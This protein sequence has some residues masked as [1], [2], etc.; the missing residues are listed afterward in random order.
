MTWERLGILLEELEVVVGER[1]VWG[2]LLR[3]LLPRI[4]HLAPDKREKM[5]KWMEEY[6]TWIILVQYEAKALFS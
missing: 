2:S 1:E 6:V 4:S 5:D 3:L